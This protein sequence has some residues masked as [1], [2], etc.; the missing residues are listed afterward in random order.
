M[1]GVD[2]ASANP[3]IYHVYTSSFYDS[4][5]DG[6]GDLR[7]IREKLDYIKSLGVDA[8][9][10]SPFYP[11]T[12]D[13]K[14]SDGGYAVSDHCAVADIYGNMDDFDELV[15]AA[16]D[17]GIEIYVDFVLCHTSDEHE[18]FQASRDPHHPEH[19]RY[20]DHYVWWT[21]PEGQSGP[22]NNWLSCF[23]DQSAWQWDDVRQAYYLRHFATSQ[24]A[25]NLNRVEVQNDVL[26]QM[27]FWAQK[28]VN[29][30]IDAIPFANYHPEL[31]DNPGYYGDGR[32]W[33]S[34][35]FQHS[36]CQPQTNELVKRIR[37]E[38]CDAYGVKAL[39]E[40]IAGREGGNNSIF[41]AS[42]YQKAGLHMAY[43]NLPIGT[44]WK[45]PTA[46]DLQS[47]VLQ[48][49]EHL[50][51]GCTINFGNHDFI[52]MASRLT[53]HAPQELHDE[54]IK[55]VLTI[56]L[57]FIPGS[58]CLY[59]GDELGLPQFDD[60][61][62][63]RRKDWSDKKRP[64]DGCRIPFPWQKDTDEIRNAGF[65]TAPEPDLYLPIPDSYRTRARSVEETDPSS[66]LNV[67]RRLIAERKA[68]P[69]LQYGD[70][71]FVDSGHPDVVAAVRRAD[72]Q[73][74][75]LAFNMSGVP[76]SLDFSHVHVNG[77]PV[78][79]MTLRAYGR[80]DRGVRTPEE[81]SRFEG[82]DSAIEPS[83]PIPGHKR[84][85]ACDMMFWDQFHQID[86][87]AHLNGAIHND[88]LPRKRLIDGTLHEALNYG[89][90]E[91][92]PGGSTSTV[93]WTLK[94]M[95]GDACDVTLLTSR[96]KDDIGGRLSAFMEN[97]DIRLVPQNKRYWGESSAISHVIEDGNEPLRVLTYTGT[98]QQDMWNYL[99]STRNSSYHD[100]ED[101]I[102]QSD[103]VYLPASVAQKYGVMLTN[104]ILKDRYFH[105]KEL[106]LALPVNA[107]FGY[108]DVNLFRGL[109]ASANV[110]IGSYDQFCR[111]YQLEVDSPASQDAIIE[112]IQLEFAKNVLQRDG[113]PQHWNGQA[114]VMLRENGDA[115]LVTAN[116]VETVQQPQ[117]K[118]EGSRL[119]SLHA[120]IAGFM[121]G[122]C[123]DL[124]HLESVRLAL[125][126][127]RIK[128][129][130]NA[131]EVFLHEPTQA[132]NT[133]IASLGD[134]H[135]A[136]A[137]S[138]IQH[139]ATEH[140]ASW[141]A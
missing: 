130:Q 107:E 135:L 18:W 2:A 48:L 65:S 58:F 34:Q 112:R 88:E 35:Y 66:V 32:S 125:Q 120:A 64:R 25:L 127:Q 45:Y 12:R 7:G 92:A 96:A 128:H 11:S 15:Q 73:E 94:E 111:L 59:N 57:H 102:A 28:G 105:Q 123:E 140:R 136:G 87:L 95:L 19:E 67:T 115:V 54:I 124:S 6:T 37:E 51:E 20:K 41:V 30:R 46:Y 50:P 9:W 29:L 116:G 76:I 106:V 101:W 83:P 108:D 27:K 38:V 62:E 89:G 75:F 74:V 141:V 33:G 100:V 60:I 119:G 72:G 10:V 85:F 84:V 16:R 118:A 122:Y 133:A 23:D 21:P 31:Y 77:A 104:A 44:M 24:P 43:T 79:R 71:T 39:G 113:M 3:V 114:A 55:Q 52:R 26:E 86:N 139:R 56:G 134:E 14:N 68:N 131:P 42:E 99:R 81:V 4:N 103:L 69:A 109:V 138:D 8:I 36:M 80:A 78:G 17:M 117:P 49:Q 1:S 53:A 70:I 82:G 93:M 22:P 13:P 129:E 40:A 91:G 98:A 63:W 90:G 110:V 126:M 132:L 137:F 97:A 61:P 121:A 47:M 5:S